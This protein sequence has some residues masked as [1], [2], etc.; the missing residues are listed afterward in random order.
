VRDIADHATGLVKQVNFINA[1][2]GAMSGDAG[3]CVLVGFLE[4]T[5]N[6]TLINAGVIGEASKVRLSDCPAM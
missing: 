5:A 1:D 3:F 6:G 2:T 4:N